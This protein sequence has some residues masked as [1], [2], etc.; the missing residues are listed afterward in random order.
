MRVDVL[1]FGGGAAGLWCLDRFRR[2]GYLTILLESTALGYGQTIQAQG[3]VHGGGKYA[4]RGVRDFAAVQA[5][6]EMPQRWRRS[7]AGELEPDLSHTRVGSVLSLAAAGLRSRLDAVLGFY[8]SACENRT[9][10]DPARTGPE[11]RL[12][13]GATRF[14]AIGL[15]FGRAGH[16]NRIIPE[17]NG[18][19]SPEI[20][21][22]V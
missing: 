3:I 4:L 15:F 13:R 6:Q 7:L 12:A 20:Y 22:S 1:I 17:N 10:L 19:P 8:P 11:F 21:S 16:R 9:A 14:G 2:A 5:T 18:E